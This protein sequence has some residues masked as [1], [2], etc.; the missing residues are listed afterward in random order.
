MLVKPDQIGMKRDSY[1]IDLWL[2]LERTMV[3]SMLTVVTFERGLLMR[4]LM[5]VRRNRI[6]GR[7]ARGMLRTERHVGA[8][9]ERHLRVVTAVMRRLDW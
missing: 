3:P 6:L 7:L 2:V 9:V 5:R 1:S 4:V 8:I